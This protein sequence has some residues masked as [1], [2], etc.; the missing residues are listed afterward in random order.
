MHNHSHTWHQR[1]FHKTSSTDIVSVWYAAIS[2]EKRSIHA[3]RSGQYNYS[4]D[5]I[6]HPIIRLCRHKFCYIHVP[7]RFGLLGRN[8]T[9]TLLSH[10]QTTSHTSNLNTTCT[11]TWTTGLSIECTLSSANEKRKKHRWWQADDG[12]SY[13]SIS[14]QSSGLRKWTSNH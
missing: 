8:Y 5:R 14:H 3:V 2:K 11:R 1:C 4:N 13:L 7:Q 6:W 9:Q 12:W 10:S